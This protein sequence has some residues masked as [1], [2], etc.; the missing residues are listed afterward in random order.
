MLQHIVKSLGKDQAKD[1]I[2]G[3]NGVLYFLEKIKPEQW[4]LLFGLFSKSTLVNRRS[5]I[6]NL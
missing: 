6:R 4:V 2:M 5:K 3:A 1:F